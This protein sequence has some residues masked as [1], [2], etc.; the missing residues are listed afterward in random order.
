MDT[1]MKQKESCSIFLK[2]K[3]KIFLTKYRDGL[4]KKKK[5]KEIIHNNNKQ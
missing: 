4:K 5:E 3:E 1:K 2:K